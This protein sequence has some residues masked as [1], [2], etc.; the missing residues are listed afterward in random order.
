MK[1]N[2]TPIKMIDVRQE[3]RI[4]HTGRPTNCWSRHCPW[5]IRTTVCSSQSAVP[6]RLAKG[7]NYNSFNFQS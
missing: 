2:R 7:Q 4:I 5:W 3:R 1:K 6:Y